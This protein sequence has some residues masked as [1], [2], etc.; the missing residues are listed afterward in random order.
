[1]NVELLEQVMRA[2]GVNN[3]DVAKAIKKDVSTWI[4]KKKSINGE[5][6]TIGEVEILCDLLSLTSLEAV[7]IF[8][9]HY[10]QKCE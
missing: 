4:R 7:E 5:N 9:P 1:M 2:Q 3:E 8:L 6:I 10:S